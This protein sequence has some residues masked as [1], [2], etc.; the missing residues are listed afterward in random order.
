MKLKR[1]LIISTAVAVVILLVVSS[2][3]SLNWAQILSTVTPQ[4]MTQSWIAG[5]EQAWNTSDVYPL[6]FSVFF[7]GIS[8]GNVAKLYNTEAVLNAEL[9]MLLQTGANAITIHLDYSAWLQNNTQLIGEYDHYI[10][11][12]EAN[13]TTVVIGDASA[14]S[15]RSEKQSW[16]Q[17][18]SE[19]IQRVETLAA[20]Y[21]PAYYVVIK[22]PDWYFS[23]L[24]DYPW[25][26]AIFSANQ[27][28]TL[29]QNLIS[30]V[31]SVSPQT[32]VGVSVSASVY[33][34]KT[35]LDINFLK[36]VIRLPGLD[37][38]GF[39]IYGT[40]GFEDTLQFLQQNGSDGKSV[41]IAE[42]WSSTATHAFDS[43][44]ASLDANWIRLLYYFA[45]KIHA[46]GISPFFT[47]ALASYG[48][49]PQD[50]VQLLS[51]YQN[52]TPVFYALKNIISTNL[53]GEK[54]N[55]T[56]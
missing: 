20:R 35:D 22:E 30:A 47:D 25:N 38:I 40:N 41:W 26:P 17:F 7:P 14:Q 46:Q 50:Q 2:A 45:L 56:S 19:W 37:F 16:S 10:K 3:Y 33:N 11:G 39:D 55:E 43:S 15:Y 42:A 54:P 32:R 36:Q 34:D 48:P 44:K 1:I 53:V 5:N 13:G 8:Y 21:H 31:K 52:R 24:S 27:W 9:G 29:T 12:L 49:R 28:V 6:V 23:M 51:Y 18:Q 4:G